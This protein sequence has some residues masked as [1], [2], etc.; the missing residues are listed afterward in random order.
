MN[1]AAPDGARTQFVLAGKIRGFRSAELLTLNC[2]FYFGIVFCFFRRFRYA[3]KCQ[4]MQAELRHR[5]LSAIMAAVNQPQ[6]IA[7]PFNPNFPKA[8]SFPAFGTAEWLALAWWQDCKGDAAKFPDADKIRAGAQLKWRCVWAE[9]YSRYSVTPPP[10]WIPDTAHFSMKHPEGWVQT[11]LD[12]ERFWLV[13]INIWALQMMKMEFEEIN[14][15]PLAAWPFPSDASQCEQLCRRFYA[16]QQA[17]Y[18]WH[19]HLLEKHCER[20]L[21]KQAPGTPIGYI[22]A[23]AKEARASLIGWLSK[24]EGFE[25]YPLVRT[26]FKKGERTAFDSERAHPS[27]RRYRNTRSAPSRPD[28]MGWLILTWPIWNFYGWRWMEVAKAVIEKFRFLDANGKPSDFLKTSRKRLQAALRENSDANGSMPAEKALALFYEHLFNPTPKEKEKHDD[29]K[30]T[31]RSRSRMSKEYEKLCR[32]AIGSGLEKQIL[33]RPRGRGTDDK[34]PLW[35]FA[36]QIS[37]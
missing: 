10:D 6:Q 14:G 36:L 17:R 8:F 3:P 19:E 35:D 4:R 28:E 27:S 26:S 31:V 37:A 30:W 11:L 9:I 7:W 15:K 21:G 32:L 1:R 20:V 22:P 34:P 18:R 33:P 12:V 16:Y 5:C 2:R 23:T 13:E 24:Q 29:W 25:D